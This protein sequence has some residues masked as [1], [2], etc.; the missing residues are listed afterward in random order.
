MGAPSFAFSGE[1]WDSTNPRRA[2]LYQGLALAMPQAPQ[3]ND[4]GFCPCR[5][6][7][8][9]CRGPPRR[10]SRVNRIPR[11]LR[12]A[13]QKKIRAF[14]S[15][16]LVSNHQLLAMAINRWLLTVSSATGYRLWLFLLFPSDKTCKSTFA[17]PDRVIPSFSRCAI[18]EVENNRSSSTRSPRSVIRT[19]TDRWL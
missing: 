10:E 7:G 3:R 11:T 5:Q 4:V 13:P 16:N 17:R 18:R 15:R 12:S 6:I 9:H 2:V 1:G 8:N 19:T 14:Q